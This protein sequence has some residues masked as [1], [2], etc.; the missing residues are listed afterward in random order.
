MQ[1]LY[2]SFNIRSYAEVV[3]YYVDWLGFKIDWEFRFAPDK[4]AYMQVS[5]DN[6]FLHLNEWE[7]GPFG[8]NAVAHVDDIKALF[9]EWKARRPDWDGTVFKTPWN[10]LRIDLEDPSGNHIAIQQDLD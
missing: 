6:L 2:P 1:R 3:E 9:K 5:R 7:E 8:S 10:V 4:P